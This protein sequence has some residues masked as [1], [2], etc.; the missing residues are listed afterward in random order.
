M[1]YCNYVS[2]LSERGG[3]IFYVVHPK[4]VIANVLQITALFQY[5]CDIYAVNFP[6]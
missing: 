4:F 3:A 5:L 2:L 6:C 1:V